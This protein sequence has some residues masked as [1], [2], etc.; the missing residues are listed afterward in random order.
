MSAIANSTS[1]ALKIMESRAELQRLLVD[2]AD[3]HAA[4]GIFPRSKTLQLFT[5][6]S[7]VVLMAIAAGGL[8][9]LRPTLIKR[10]LRIVPLGAMVRML[11]TRFMRNQL[12]RY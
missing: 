12:S 8:I 11:A 5:S 4:S 2:N 7:G 10:A 3:E 9:L 1:A 6:N